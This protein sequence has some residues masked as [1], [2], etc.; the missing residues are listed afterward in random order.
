M[1]M[2]ELDLPA[3]AIPAAALP[4]L[5]DALT[6]SLL[7]RRGVP[8]T[9]ASRANVWTFVRTYGAEQLFVGGAGADRPVLCARVS[10]VEGGMGDA[11]KEGLVAEFTQ[12]LLGACGER[13]AEPERVWVLV[14]EVPDGNWGAGGEVTRLQDAQRIL[15]A[16]G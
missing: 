1:P 5:A 4:G 9:P 3:D 15:Q 14:A 8:D 13:L 11:D 10:I 7:R 2:I 16:D 6:A 12:Q